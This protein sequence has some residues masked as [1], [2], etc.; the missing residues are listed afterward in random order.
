MR[1]VFIIALFFTSLD[2]AAQVDST[3]LKVAMKKLDQALLE[4]DAMVLASLLHK[5]ASFGHS[6]AWVQS[7]QDVLDDGKTGKL[8]YSKI[9]NSS[10]RIVAINKKW[11]TVRS[12]TNAEGVA[13]GNAFKLTLHVLQVWVKTKKGWQLMAR[14]STKI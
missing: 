4:K 13:N 7:R 9:E 2:L 3:G 10:V 1:W 5:D 6:N 8:V 11:A 14:Q 12:N